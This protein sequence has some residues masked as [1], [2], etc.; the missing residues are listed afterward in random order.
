VRQEEALRCAAT[1]ETFYEIQQ[2]SRPYLSFADVIGKVRD[3][4]I[5]Q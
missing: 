1:D 5:N 2:K 3:I 4:A